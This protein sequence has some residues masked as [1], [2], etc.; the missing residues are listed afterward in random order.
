MY[1]VPCQKL[2]QMFNLVVSLLLLIEILFRQL[3]SRIILLNLQCWL[4]ERNILTILEVCSISNFY[5]AKFSCSLLFPLYCVSMLHTLDE[6][7]YSLIQ[8]IDVL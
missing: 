2:L 6:V 1:V 7:I 3:I 8:P 4:L 5:L